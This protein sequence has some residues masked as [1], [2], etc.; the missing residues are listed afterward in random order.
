MI[1]R[2]H[3]AAVT[4]YDVV[5]EHVCWS[6]CARLNLRGATLGTTHVLIDD[7]ATCGGFDS[8]DHRLCIAR[9]VREHVSDTPGRQQRRFSDNL[10]RQAL[11]SGG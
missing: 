11:D 7:L 5:D 9:Q 8:M 1:R 10:I 3:Q 2:W 4:N 6:S